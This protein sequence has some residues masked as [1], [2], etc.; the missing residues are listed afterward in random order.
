[1]SS[2]AMGDAMVSLR[3]TSVGTVPNEGD[4]SAVVEPNLRHAAS[5]LLVGA[6]ARSSV[7]LTVLMP[8]L[9]EAQTVPAC[10]GKAKAFLARAGIR[11]RSAGGRQRLDR[12][13][14]G[15]GPAAGARVVHVPER[16]Y[17]AALLARHRRR[18]QAATSSWATLTTA[19]TSV[20]SSRSSPKLR[21]ANELVMGNRF[22]GGIKPGAMP[23]LHR[24]LGNPVLQLRRPAVLPRTHRRLP[25]RP[26]R[27]STATPC[28]G[29][30]CHDGHGVRQRDGRQG[31]AGTA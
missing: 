31:G 16:G 10:I 18:A 6:A 21:A 24:Y 2:R 23:S 28:A 14:A 4:K 29:S 5:E 17:G 25:L 30:A 27:L 12:R 15:P 13:L 11:R 26:A 1:M 22:Q 8:C 9:N 19:T 3:R 20:R 7:E